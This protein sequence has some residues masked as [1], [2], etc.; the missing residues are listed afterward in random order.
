MDIIVSTPYEMRWFR[1]Q[2]SAFRG[3]GSNRWQTKSPLQTAALESKYRQFDL[4][5]LFSA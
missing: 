4:R 2:G 3:Q 5:R 1:G